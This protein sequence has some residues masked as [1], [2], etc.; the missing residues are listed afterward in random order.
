M[1]RS[2]PIPVLP[3]LLSRL[4]APLPLT[5]L[6]LLVER[7][8]QG[9][10][11]RHPGLFE[12]L[13]PYADRAFL[14][15][16]VDLPMGFLMRPAPTG[17]RL[18]AVRR[19]DRT[20]HDCRIAGPLAALLGMIHGAYDGDALFFSRDIVMEGDTEAAV[21]LRNALDDAE[22]DLFA[23]AA[24]TL[25]PPGRLFADRFRPLVEAVGRRAGVALTRADLARANPAWETT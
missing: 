17:L 11:E 21:A 15:D 24:E 10:A 14:I 20:G 13:G 12:R 1:S 6:S 18:K 5:P 7:V 22:L 19:G 4:A 8:A 23:E 9:V 16:P 25:G 3:S 2:S